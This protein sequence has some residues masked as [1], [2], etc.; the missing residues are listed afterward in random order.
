MFSSCVIQQDA[1]ITGNPV[2]DK[3]VVLK[4]NSF[5]SDQDVSLKTACEK[6]NIQK[7]ATVDLKTSV[8]I[9]QFQKLI[10]TGQ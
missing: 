5:K 10:V 9:I 6:G 7:V 3:K 1:M 2:G 8:F 4:S